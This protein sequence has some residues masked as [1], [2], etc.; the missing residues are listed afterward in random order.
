MSTWHPGGVLGDSAWAFLPWL[1][2]VLL[3][4]VLQGSV[5]HCTTSC[6]VVGAATVAAGTI[7]RAYCRASHL[8]PLSRGACGS[9]ATVAGGDAGLGSRACWGAS[10]RG[11]GLRMG[12][13]SYST[14]HYFGQNWSY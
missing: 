7:A 6:Q 4:L 5:V 2:V 11:L 12:F 1:G 13:P 14:K 9:L 3:C 8:E 10:L